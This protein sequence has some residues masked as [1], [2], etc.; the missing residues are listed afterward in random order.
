[1]AKRKAKQQ[2]AEIEQPFEVPAN[3]V[4]IYKD[5]P[6]LPQLIFLPLGGHICMK[7]EGDFEDE[8]DEEAFH[9]ELNYRF[10]ESMKWK[11][12]GGHNF[13]SWLR[14]FCENMAKGLFTVDS[15]GR[16][17]NTKR[18]DKALVVG[19]GPSTEKLKMMD[20]SEYEIFTCWHASPRIPAEIDYVVHSARFMPKDM[21]PQPLP[22]AIFVGECTS[23]PE[24]YDT[25][26]AFGNA[27]YL[28]YNPCNF[29]DSMLC[30]VLHEKPGPANIGTVT[31]MTINTAITVGHQDITLIGVD[32]TTSIKTFEGW[33]AMGEQ[34]IPTNNIYR[35][36]LESMAAHYANVKFYNLSDSQIKG[37][38][39]IESP[40]A[41]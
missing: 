1:M 27:V 26:S 41:Q 33:D 34:A 35:E 13:P 7:V 37:F 16:L 29:F 28:H 20:L 15:A 32:L 24:F 18:K 31:S 38:S 40:Q 10:E 17:F 6:L 5:Q 23:A 4:T 22:G 12:L 3:C 2:I 21:I 19:A 30:D 9:N 8:A 36:C 11:A 39:N 14:N 25:A